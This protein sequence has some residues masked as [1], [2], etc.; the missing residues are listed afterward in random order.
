M[1]NV[2]R[3][4]V[5]RAGRL[6]ARLTNT[7]TGTRRFWL[8]PLGDGKETRRRVCRMVGVGLGLCWWVAIINKKNSIRTFYPHTSNKYSTGAGHPKFSKISK[9]YD[10][11]G[12][13]ASAA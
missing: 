8:G 1:R 3:D 2:T 11:M 7:D 4:D 12:R 6:V 13:N 9:T 10:K 5:Q